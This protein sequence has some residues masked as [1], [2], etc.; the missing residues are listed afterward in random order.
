MPS[1]EVHLLFQVS[2]LS[3]ITTSFVFSHSLSQVFDVVTTREPDHDVQVV[4]LNEHVKQDASHASQFVPTCIVY[5]LSQLSTHVLSLRSK[6][7][8]VMQEVH[9]VFVSAHVLQLLF[10]DSHLSEVEL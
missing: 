10:Q 8:L 3:L 5:K 1:Q 6:N 4:V 9:V 2:Q 7:L